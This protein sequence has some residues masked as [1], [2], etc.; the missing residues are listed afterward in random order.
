MPDPHA[1]L[2]AWAAQLAAGIP[3]ICSIHLVGSRAGGTES[4][5]SDYDLIA[6][7]DGGRLLGIRNSG[8]IAPEPPPA[9]I[10]AHLPGEPY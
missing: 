9:S 4:P 10:S 8:W 7:V 3:E 2:R 1:E 5:S 6:I